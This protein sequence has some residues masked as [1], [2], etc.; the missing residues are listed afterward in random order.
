M[1]KKGED[2]K[3]RKAISIKKNRN[4]TSEKGPKQKQNETEM[5]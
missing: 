5:C 1:P 3:I 4:N 2:L